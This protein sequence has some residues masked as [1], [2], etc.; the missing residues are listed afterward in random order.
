MNPIKKP[1]KSYQSISVIRK[2][3]QQIPAEGR[4]TVNNPD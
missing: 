2:E 3:S 4:P 1:I